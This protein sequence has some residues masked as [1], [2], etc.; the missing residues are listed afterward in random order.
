MYKYI[1]KKKKTAQ[2]WPLSTFSGKG[3]V[4]DTTT[5]LA[6]AAFP[7]LKLLPLLLWVTES[8]ILQVSA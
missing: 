1:K 3:S 8:N 6:W 4:L 7:L 2:A 5:E